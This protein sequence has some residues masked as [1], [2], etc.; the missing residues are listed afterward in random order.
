MTLI[1]AVL[2]RNEATRYLRDV[3]ENLNTFCDKIVLLDDH[4]TDTTVKLAESLGAEVTKLNGGGMW[5]NETPARQAL[6]TVAEEAAGDGWIYFADADHIT[7]GGQILRQLTKTWVCNS[8]AM[9]LYDVWDEARQFYRADGY[10][11]GHLY[12]RIWMVAPKRVPPGWFPKW[13]GRG[14]HSGHIPP[15]FPVHAGL[16]PSECFIEHLGWANPLERKSKVDRYLSVAGQL[17]PQEIAH[18][19]SALD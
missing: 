6:W 16:C 19:R 2:A 18:A 15:N 10:W 8:W 17:T 13:P 5:G 3:L 9:P 4:S 12:P 11:V 7:H 1:G 14:V